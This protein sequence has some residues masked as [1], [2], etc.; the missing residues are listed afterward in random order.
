MAAAPSQWLKGAT[1]SQ[2]RGST[3]E[4]QCRGKG[5][6]ALRAPRRRR[7]RVDVQTHGA[8]PPELLARAPDTRAC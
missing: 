5:G 8:G 3:R 6:T 1:A 4:A 7:A 2:P